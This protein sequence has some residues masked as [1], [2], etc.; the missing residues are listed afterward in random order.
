MSA[1]N[2]EAQVR[3]DLE[4]A[5]QKIDLSAVAAVPD[6]VVNKKT[7]RKLLRL[8]YEHGASGVKKVNVLANFDNGSAP[9]QLPSGYSM[10]FDASRAPVVA[11]AFPIE[12][13][14]AGV[15]AYRVPTSELAAS[16]LATT[17]PTVH[18]SEL[19]RLLADAP[20]TPSKALPDGYVGLFSHETR[21]NQDY[22][23]DY[24][25]VARD[26]QPSLN[27]AFGDIL[28][29]AHGDEGVTLQQ[30]LREGN[31][32]R[33]KALKAQRVARAEK[34]AALLGAYHIRVDAESILSGASSSASVSGQRDFTDNCFNS[35]L[36]DDSCK[37]AVLF[38]N[39]V[40]LNDETLSSGLLLTH[41][42]RLGPTLLSGQ[43]RGHGEV[44][45]D[46]IGAF[47]STMPCVV[48]AWAAAASVLPA[49]VRLDE[50]C[51]KN[52][53][54]SPYTWTSAHERHPMLARN[55][56]ASNTSRQW[57][58]YQTSSGFSAERS[59]QLRPLAVHLR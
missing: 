57:I 29:S 12:T 45:V 54:N 11:E 44:D 58:E 19:V 20:C 43:P 15:S 25:V 6:V 17:G 59:T 41:T 1:E 30:V 7:C 22:E 21:Q 39:A 32:E 51:V 35:I 26:V 31:S 38:C 52:A 5:V 37:T 53:P 46:S 47:P 2:V 49:T 33:F 4:R 28:A 10:A 56:Y 24:F 48:S 34:L 36:T 55:L 27:V 50:K 40:P 23:H 8:I 14:F 42:Q 13:L 18:S 16:P 9:E 3:G